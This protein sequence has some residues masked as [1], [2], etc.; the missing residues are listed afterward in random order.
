MTKLLNDIRVLLRE[1]SPSARVGEVVE[2]RTSSVVVKT[3]VGLK[4]YTVITPGQF[5]V[6]DR[7][8]LSGDIAVSKISSTS[9]L[10]TFQV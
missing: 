5:R 4:E 9:S 3:V 7:V 2:V 8:R 10:P 1:E 6:G